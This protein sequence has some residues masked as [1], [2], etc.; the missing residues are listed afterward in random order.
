MAFTM[1]FAIQKRKQFLYIKNIC[2]Y[3][4]LEAKTNT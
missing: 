3:F 4:N 1:T 2:I